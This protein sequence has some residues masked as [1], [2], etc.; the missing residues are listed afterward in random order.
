ML[1]VS[2]GLVVIWF[3]FGCAVRW[4]CAGC[5]L[6][7]LCFA[8]LCF[9]LLCFALLCFDCALVALWLCFV[10]CLCVGGALCF[11]LVVVWL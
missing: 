2:R 6:R 3:W 10:L 4:L 8:L 11:V 9:A 5:D 7:W 1:C